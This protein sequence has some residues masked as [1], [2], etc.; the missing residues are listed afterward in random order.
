MRSMALTSLAGALGFLLLW[1]VV[2]VIGGYPP[3]ILPSPES[4][5]VRLA[6]AWAEGLMAPHAATTLVEVALGF[7]V[8]GAVGL[9]V[10]YALGLGG[11]WAGSRVLET[12]VHG[13]TTHDTATF[14]TAPLVLIA[15]VLAALVVPARRA[16][17]LNPMDVIR[18]E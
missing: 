1:K 18:A 6:E 2:V 7:T 13:V 8:G 9:I 12:M 4:V 3:F 14:I 15:P 10:G 17:R 5:I 16:L 11:A